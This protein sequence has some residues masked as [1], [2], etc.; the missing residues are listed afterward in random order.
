MKNVFIAILAIVSCA[1]VY[2]CFQSIKNPIDFQAEKESREE[3]IITRLIDIRKAQAQYKTIKG[4][5]TP[6]FDE[7]ISFLKN[8]NIP[9]LLKEG[10]LTDEQLQSGMTEAEAV[11]KGLIKRDTLWVNA[12]DTLFGKDANVDDLAKV[13]FSD[14]KFKMDTATV[15]TASDLPIYVFECSVLYDQYLHG[16]DA[17]E[18]ANLNHHAEVQEKFAGLRVGDLTMANNSA[19]NW[20]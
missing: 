11:K 12:K 20:E 7:L 2:V 3:A 4:K 10:V 9:F 13:P 5:H 16:M 14:A 15:F 18:V 1:L 19:G 17:Q 6:S 8:E